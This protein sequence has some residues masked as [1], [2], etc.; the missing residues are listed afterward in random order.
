MTEAE[1]KAHIRLAIGELPH[2]RLFNNP[3]GE[4]WMGEVISGPRQGIV[5]LDHARRVSFGLAA[6]SAD[7]CGYTTVTV[8]PDMVGQRLAVF[9]SM[10]VKRPTI[11]KL[12]E[13]QENWRKAVA[14]AGG[15]AGMVRS[16]DEARKLV[17]AGP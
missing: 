4:A 10:E 6:G 3:V 5:T 8:T 12:P 1:V 14:D 17:G 15:F 16:A 9:T 2:V 11:R 13:P 7:L